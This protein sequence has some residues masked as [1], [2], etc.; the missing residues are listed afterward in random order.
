MLNWKAG[1]QGFVSVVTTSIVFILGAEY[2]GL[3]VLPV[4]LSVGIGIFILVGWLLNKAE[5]EI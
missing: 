2:L 5:K 4:A 3:W 1:I